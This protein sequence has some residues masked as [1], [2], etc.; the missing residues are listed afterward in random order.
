MPSLGRTPGELVAANVAT[1]TGEGLGAFL[2]PLAAGIAL[3]LAGPGIAAIVAAGLLAAGAPTLIG[4]PVSADEL[5]EDAA[6]ARGRGDAPAAGGRGGALRGRGG[7][8]AAPRGG[9]GAA[10]R[11]RDL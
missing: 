10:A 1:S 8:R 3:A 5:G 7:G 9:P 11:G 2:G 4:L 6:N